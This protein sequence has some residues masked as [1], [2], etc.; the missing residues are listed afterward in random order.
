MEAGIFWIAWFAVA[1]GIRYPE[2]LGALHAEQWF[3]FGVRSW[4]T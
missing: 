1:F 2:A 4:A 3:G